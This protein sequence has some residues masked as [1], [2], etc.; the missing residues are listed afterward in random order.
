MN[1]ENLETLIQLMNDHQLKVISY[2]DKETEY[3]IEKAV[4]ALAAVP[5]E[6]PVQNEVKAASE[7]YIQKS[8]L[9]GTFYNTENEDSTEPLVKVGQKVEKGDRI[10]IIEAMKVMNDI[11]AEVSGTIEEILVESGTAV[12]Y[13]EPLV[14]IKEV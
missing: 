13:D 3:H 8:Q 7:G 11:Q 4:P 12:S 5:L 6:A 9:V 10:G 14:K 1:T 2:K